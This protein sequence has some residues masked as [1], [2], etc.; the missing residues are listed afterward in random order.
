LA[1]LGSDRPAWVATHAT[2]RPAAVRR[3][4]NCLPISWFSISTHVDKIINLRVIL[5]E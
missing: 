4:R 3:A 5:L 1:L 2:V